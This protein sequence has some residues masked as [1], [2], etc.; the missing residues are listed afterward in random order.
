MESET[1]SSNSS[2]ASASA[3]GWDFQSN[4]AIMLMLKYIERAEKVKVEGKTQDIEITFSDGMILMSQAKSIMRVDD[5]QNVIRNLKDGLKTL[6]EA[7][8]LSGVEQLV[9]ITNSPN[10]FNDKLTISQFSSP[11]NF[12]TFSELHSNAKKKD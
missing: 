2:N 7:A 8:K 4:A 11:T 3:F 1:F 12:V 5:Y 10:P 9:Y 6:N